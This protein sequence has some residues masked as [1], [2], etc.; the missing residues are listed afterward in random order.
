MHNTLFTNY[1]SFYSNT[2]RWI[3]TVSL[4]RKTTLHFPESEFYVM[5]FRNTL[6]FPYL[7]RWCKQGAYVAYEDGRKCSET[8][9]HKI[10]SLGNHP[11]KK[12]QRLEQGECLKSSI[13]LTCWKFHSKFW[14]I[15]V[16]YGTHLSV[17]FISEKFEP[18]R[19]LRPIYRT[20]GPLASRCCILHIFFNKYKYWVFYAAHF[21]FFPSKCCLFNNATFFV[22]CIIRILHTECAKI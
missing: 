13:V 18:L 11:P 15:Q 22:S 4:N 8:S 7:Y 9:E 16:G 19:T 2:V 1:R 3:W 20:G 21:P 5:T 6:S 14:I 10:Q 12:T 17:I